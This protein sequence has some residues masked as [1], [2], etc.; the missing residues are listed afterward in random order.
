LTLVALGWFAMVPI[1]TRG[2]GLA[3]L[4]A[5]NQPA[6]WLAAANVMVVLGGGAILFRTVAAFSGEGRLGSI[7]RKAQVLGLGMYLTALVLYLA[8]CGQP[9]R[10]WFLVAQWD[11]GNPLCRGI[12]GFVVCLLTLFFG[13][14]R[15]ILKFVIVFSGLGAFILLISQ[16]SPSLPVVH[17]RL[18]APTPQDWLVLAFALGCG[19]CASWLRARGLSKSTEEAAR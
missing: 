4:D 1:W 6:L 18:V 5:D 12:L 14:N 15:G 2:L 7:M 19:T 10:V 17:G 8:M 16:V 11:W 3:A 13:S 9:L